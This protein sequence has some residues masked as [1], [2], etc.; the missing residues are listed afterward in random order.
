MAL[1][2]KLSR[3]SLVA[4]LAGMV[5]AEVIAADGDLDPTFGIGG[6]V[7]TSLGFPA[8]AGTGIALYPDGRIV[9]GGFTFDNTANIDFAVVR[10][11]A[12][13]LL[14]STFGAGGTTVTDFFGQYDLPNAIAI[15]AD[16]KIVLA[17][18]TDAFPN[19]GYALARYDANGSLDPTFD[20][21]GRVFGPLGGIAYAVAIQPD[22]KIVAAGTAL[23]R[24][25]P[26]GSLDSTF[27]A[28]G[29]V[30]FGPGM[31]VFAVA[32][33]P[34]GKIIVAGSISQDNRPTGDDWLLLRYF[35]DGTPDPSFGASGV[36][37]TD[38]FQSGDRASALALQ[39]D[40]KIV[41]AG[42]AAEPGGDEGPSFAVARY[43]IDGRLDNSFDGDGRRA[44]NLAG[45]SEDVFDVAIQRDGKIVVGGIAANPDF[46]YD[47]AL[48]RLNPDGSDDPT[49]GALGLVRTD[50]FGGS[51]GLRGLAIQPNGRIVAAGSASQGA[52]FALAGYLG[53]PGEAPPAVPT[54]SF[55]MLA[56]LGVALAGIGFL[57]SRRL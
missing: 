48:L 40:G 28:G 29:K 35:P 57:A 36:V 3:V 18:S 46:S 11:T 4:M 24:Y 9:V 50:F 7:T 20:G 55:P 23:V 41:A 32:V 26:D 22:G 49:F 14:D 45:F 56:L 51:D 1:T 30:V 47:F 5:S 8:Q 19:N 54:L 21:D 17:G 38:F 15:Q 42:Y 52:L 31:G 27:G 12:N 44:R 34:D 43:E 39:P 33:Q 10:Y 16:G 13:G 6:R 25:N 53:A 2:R 37:T